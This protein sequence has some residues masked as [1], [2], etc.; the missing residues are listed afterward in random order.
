MSTTASPHS[1]RVRYA[2]LMRLH[3]KE[4]EIDIQVKRKTDI[5]TKETLS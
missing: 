3:R 4:D 2:N 5:S 1:V